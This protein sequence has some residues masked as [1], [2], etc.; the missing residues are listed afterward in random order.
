[1]AKHVGTKIT[2]AYS[3]TQSSRRIF[4]LCNACKEVLAEGTWAL[5]GSMQGVHF[6]IGPNPRPTCCGEERFVPFLFETPGAAQ[7]KMNMVC[8]EITERKTHLIYNYYGIEN[9]IPK[10]FH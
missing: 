10:H 2:I 9:F 7:D 1:M 3:L 4:S 6:L 8:N 5:D